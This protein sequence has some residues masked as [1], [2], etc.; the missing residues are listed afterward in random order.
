MAPP[1]ALR[2]LEGQGGEKFDAALVSELAHAL[3]PYP[4]GTLVEM[5][6]GSLGLVWS[7]RPGQPLQPN[8]IV[9]HDGARQLLAEPQL[10]VAHGAADIVRS[11]PP[12]TARMDATRIDNALR[13][14]PPAA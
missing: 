9:T 4:V 12:H 13:N 10:T 1:A 6:D 2:Q 7:R 3:G 5:V 14:L 8:V 11:L